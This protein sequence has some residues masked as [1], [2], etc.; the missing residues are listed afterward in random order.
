MRRFLLTT[1]AATAIMLGGCVIVVDENGRIHDGD[2]LHYSTDALN[3][4]LDTDGDARLVGPDITVTGRADGTV[5]VTGADFVARDL[6]AGAVNATAADIR[7]SGSVAGD[8]ELQAADVRWRGPVGG[9][10]EVSAADLNFDGSVGD[11]LSASVADARLSGEFGALNL[12]AADVHLTG[13]AWVNGDVDAAAATFR[14]D[15]MIEGALD[16]SAK[17]VFLDGDVDGQVSIQ[18][19]PG[20]APWRQNDGR[21]EINGSL[22]GGEIC[23]RHVVITG[24][25]T[26]LLQVTADEAPHVEGGSVADIEFTPRNG[27]RCDNGW[28]G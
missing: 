5:R 16:L 14:H 6:Q 15:G 8:V 27:A 3:T 23:A 2:K 9:A 1:A 20:R 28:E 19:D 21:V 11:Q 22:A 10:F 24:E 13:E 12:R 4:V 18:A 7:Y 26:G 25:V 17:T